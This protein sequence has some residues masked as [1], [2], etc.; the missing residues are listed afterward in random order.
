[1]TSTFRF[2]RI[3]G[4]E[5]GAHWTWLLVV[6]L[7]VWSL[8]TTVFPATSPDLSAQ[9]HL[10][11]ALVAAALF[12][13][14]LLGHE[15]GHALQARRD[16]VPIEGIT[17]WVF[18]GVARFA[19]QPPT[20]A[21]ELRVALA[22]PA[23]SLAVGVAGVGLAALLALPDAVEA[24]VR[25]LGYINLFLLAFN[26]L[27]AFPLDGGRVVR[28]LLWRQTHDLPRATRWAAAAGRT[29]AMVMVAGGVLLAILAGDLSGLWLA[30]LGFFL[31]SAAET[32]LALVNAQAALGGLRVG[33][34]M[35]RDPVSVRAD[36]PL[37]RFFDDVF[38]AHR[39]T[40]YPVVDDGP[41]GLVSFR[42]ALDVPRDQW[43][44][45][46]VADRMLP[47]E[48]ALVVDA[49]RELADVVGEL[50]H[51]GVHRALVRRDGELAG[52][53]SVTDAAR[54]LEARLGAHAALR[55]PAPG[56]SPQ[57]ARGTARAVARG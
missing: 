46:R 49:D 29:F 19:G 21:S 17:L 25:W 8:A 10:A 40:A 23:V 12:F 16:G 33:D 42:D 39:H 45:M 54:V 38:L 32:E 51:D 2:G 37:D 53:L 1:M 48:R 3:A 57:P 44:H 36:L 14:S 34:I 5:I 6:A 9:T 47:L 52:L 22:G 28:A 13:A 35:V 4:I 31:L 7:V 43:P 50:T 20:A 41:V 26:L 11:M 55:D 56:I 24:V 30:L 15:L 27:P 18:G